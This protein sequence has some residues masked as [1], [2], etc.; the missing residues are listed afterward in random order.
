MELM[1]FLSYYR[2]SQQENYMS[3][4]DKIAVITGAASGIGRD[5]AKL[6]ARR[7]V[8]VA[9]V[10]VDQGGLN[11]VIDEIRAEGGDASGIVANLA[12]A[13]QAASVVERAAAIYGGVDI[14]W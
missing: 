5:G 14:V 3:I 9:A 11:R 1:R 8:K 7:G 6:F 10:D 12:I 4:A 2:E 13:E